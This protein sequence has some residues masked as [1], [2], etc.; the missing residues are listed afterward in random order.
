MKLI[1]IQITE[2][3]KVAGFYILLEQPFALICLS[4]EIYKADER[5]LKKLDERGIKYK[6][7]KNEEKA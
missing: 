1:N 5:A 4:D 6:I 3:D 7:L 2:V